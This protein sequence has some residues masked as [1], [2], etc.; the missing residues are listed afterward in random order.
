MPI[1]K[2]TAVKTVQQQKKAS[3][4]KADTAKERR[5][6]QVVDEV[7]K[8]YGA[9]ALSKGFPKKKSDED[10]WY[11]IQRFGT[12][13]PSLDIALGGGI[14]VGRYTEI[15]GAFSSYKTTVTLH[16][17]REFQEKFGKTVL[18]CDAEGT[19]TDDGG[20]YLS[21]LN[22]NEDLFMY[23]QSAGLEETTQMILDMM[24]NPDVKLGVIDSIEA[25]VPTKE[26]NSDMEDTVQMGIKP[27]LLA[28]FFR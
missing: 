10:D 19:T 11:T 24:D 13:V 23:N 21:Q 6:A 5:L 7:N 20:L 28:E 26:Y 22:I 18:L 16:C 25:L 1:K 14:P 17:I 8:K 2:K 9:N 4:Q 12:S 15:Q 3:T 27:K